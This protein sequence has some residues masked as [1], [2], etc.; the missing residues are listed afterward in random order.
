MR[1]CIIPSLKQLR[2]KGKKAK[3][4]KDDQWPGVFVGERMA[5]FG[6]YNAAIDMGS[7]YILFQHGKSGVI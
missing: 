3:L 6:G 1:S 5:K 4:G 7:L 2:F